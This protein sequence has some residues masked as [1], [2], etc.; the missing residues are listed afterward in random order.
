VLQN[1][2][3]P[4]PR[5]ERTDYHSQPHGEVD[6]RKKLPRTFKTV[7]VD[8]LWDYES[9]QADQDKRGANQNAHPK[10]E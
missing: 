9:Q 1:A 4:P 3:S 2:H 7:S 8:K 10:W 6:E 5:H